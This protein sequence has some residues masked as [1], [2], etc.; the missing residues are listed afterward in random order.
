MTERKG[1]EK[2]SR[3]VAGQ[4]DIRSDN[5][6]LSFGRGAKTATCKSLT[7]AQGVQSA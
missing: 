6:F 2:W 5:F 7:K 4:T 3:F 1:T